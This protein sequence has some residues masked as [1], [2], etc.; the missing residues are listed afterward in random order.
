MTIEKKV[1][2]IENLLSQLVP[3]F[4]ELKS[5]VDTIEIM[6]RKE[7]LNQVGIGENDIKE[8]IKRTRS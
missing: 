1:E 8:L 7:S 6:I 5:R 2:V 3:G 4:L